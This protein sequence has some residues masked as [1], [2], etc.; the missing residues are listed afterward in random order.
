MAAYAL[1][2]AIVV[3]LLILV[4]PTVTSATCVSPAPC[5]LW[6]VTWRETSSAFLQ[7]VLFGRLTKAKARFELLQDNGNAVRLYTGGGII[8]LT[9]NNVTLLEAVGN[10]T[11]GQEFDAWAR[12][13]LCSTDW[14]RSPLCGGKCPAGSYEDLENRCIGC[15]A[16]KFHPWEITD[17]T[18]LPDTMLPP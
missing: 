6:V 8:N 15:S 9:L 10:T 18:Y 7:G 2:C 16:G 13:A 14:S 12:S 11:H 17:C 4:R 1:H 3:V 5:Q